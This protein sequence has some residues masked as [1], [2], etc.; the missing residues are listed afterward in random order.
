MKRIVITLLTVFCAVCLFAQ[1]ESQ[2]GKFQ[3]DGKVYV[4]SFMADSDHLNF[5]DRYSSDFKMT[6]E[7]ELNGKY[8]HNENLEFNT[9]V[10]VGNYLNMLRLDP[11]ERRSVISP[12]LYYL[13][14]VY[15]N[16][17]F[18]KL[19]V[20]SFGHQ[21]HPYVFKRT[22]NDWYFPNDRMGSGNFQLT[23][24]DYNNKIGSFDY[25]VWY[26][27]M[28]KNGFDDSDIYLYS[29]NLG[30]IKDVYG[31]KIGYDFKPVKAGAVYSRAT[32]DYNSDKNNTY[33]VFVEVPNKIADLNANYFETKTKNTDKD[34]MWDVK[35]S[36]TFGKLNAGLSYTFI[37]ERYNAPGD[38]VF[39]CGNNSGVKGYKIDLGYKFSDEFSIDGYYQWGKSFKTLAE[40]DVMRSQ[41][42]F[43]YNI[44]PANYLTFQWRNRYFK[45][46]DTD[47][48]FT[49][50][51]I[52]KY[53]HKFSDNIS[54]LLGYENYHVTMGESDTT[55]A[56]FTQLKYTF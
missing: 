42:N 30:K 25:D 39:Y 15:R 27:R 36:K 16:K 13:N 29:Y 3:F 52:L 46:D 18:G 38:W 8:T 17:D 23:G 5:D 45:F 44:D 19:T 20:G 10:T 6:A 40:G 24:A 1:E 34:R 2:N 51:F 28:G 26:G 49:N 21:V 50:F 33:G 9:T 12:N 4:N 41:W 22:C 48:K 31:G 55:G 32:S 7:L 47:H 11:Y 37:G 54:M 53:T 43:N 56:V 35:L 14:G